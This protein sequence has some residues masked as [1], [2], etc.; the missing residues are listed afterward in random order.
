VTS[1]DL[2]PERASRIRAVVGR[3]LRYLGR[4]RVH[5][6]IESHVD[7]GRVVD[8]LGRLSPEEYEKQ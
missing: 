5:C 7:Y 4:L 1:E 8:G 3:Q 2:T 6:R